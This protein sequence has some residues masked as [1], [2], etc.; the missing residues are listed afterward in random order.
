MAVR[1]NRVR[2]LTAWR[3]V[4]DR[5]SPG[6]KANIARE[7]AG[8]DVPKMKF[9]FTVS[10][11][12][13]EALSTY[14]NP[15]SDD[16]AKIEYACKSATRPNVNVNYVEVNSYNY[17]FKVATRTDVGTVTLTLYDDNK[18]TA[19]DI[20]TNYLEAISPVAQRPSGDSYYLKDDLQYWAS[21]GP[22]PTAE[23]DGLIKTMRVTHHYN[24]NNTLS[25]SNHRKIHYDYINPKI[26]TFALDDLDMSASDVNTIT[27]TFV[28]DSVNIVY[29][30]GTENG[31]PQ[32]IL[33]DGIEDV[34]DIDTGG[35]RF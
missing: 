4:N 8:R 27:L 5:T 13:G 20:V 31:R 16:M 34:F 35:Q 1:D 10:F 6:Q 11:N 9:L 32:V 29:D 17:R 3:L 19:H 26:Q 30:N 28:Y 15:G 14:I 22:L 18:N 2:N 33:N 24:E 12:L 21:L 25:A 23:A 7:F